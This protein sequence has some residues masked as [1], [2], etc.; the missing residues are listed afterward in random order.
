MRRVLFIAYLYPPIA[1]SGTRRSLSFANHLPDFGWEPLVLTVANPAPKYCDM[2]LMAEI[3][4]GTHVERVPTVSRKLA[5]KFAAFAGSTR[6]ARVT[7]GLE[8]R[9][10]SLLRVPDE[11]AGWYPTA[12]RRGVELHRSMGF[13]A[14]Y[15]S[16]SPWTSFL[17]ARAVAARTGCPYILD[18]RDPWRSTGTVEWDRQTAMQARFGPFLELRAGRA[19][20]AV[21]TTTPTLVPSI[22]EASG[23]RTV[24]SITNGFEPSDFECD[25]I[26]PDDGL[27]RVAYTGVWRPGYGPD[28]LYR[29]VRRLKDE[30]SP[31]L[32]RLK[33]VTA[34][35]APGPAAEFGIEDIVEEL[36]RVPHLR[37][38]QIMKT[39]DM[40]YLPV[41]DGYYA[42]ASLPGKLFEYL[43]S[44]TPLVAAV[45]AGSEVARV[46]AD[47]GGSARVEPG[48]DAALARVLERLCQ[49]DA[50]SLLSE[51]RPE[52][53]E[54]Y[55][56]RS[57]TGSLAEVLNAACSG[58]SI[59]LVS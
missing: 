22:R 58:E 56:R 33:V 12:V 4:Q 1:N 15:A 23:A 36:G 40:L 35:Y 38:V 30:A 6:R 5:E 52:R 42:D 39:A 14:V 41:S 34:G 31:H 10:S 54:R 19:A 18:Y 46:L 49:G 51:R 21:I 43:G 37:A 27:V 55:T 45:P 48:D 28:A 13:D 2:A 32:R 7:D 59:E 53:L 3:R 57:I 20:T 44:T 50:A 24:Y 9:I 11:S 8:W 29:A 17:V 26:R 16:G 47:V 25:A